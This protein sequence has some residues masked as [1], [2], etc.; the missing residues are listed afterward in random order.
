MEKVIRKPKEW[1]EQC[2][3]CHGSGQVRQRES[4]ALYTPDEYEVQPLGEDAD[5]PQGTYVCGVWG[6]SS[7]FEACKEGVGLAGRVNRPVAF[8]FNDTVVVCRA[9]S[10]PESVAKEWYP[11]SLGKTYEQ[12]MAGR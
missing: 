8:R 1:V 6:G 4:F 3:H 11:R 9:D 10:D 2:S 12:S 5:V 7:I